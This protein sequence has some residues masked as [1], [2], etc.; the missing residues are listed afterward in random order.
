MAFTITLEPDGHQFSAKAYDTVLDSAVKAGHNIPYGCRNG[1][2]GSCKGK[3]ISGDVDYG[4][5]ADTALSDAE[6]EAG[7]ALL[8]CALP[9]SDLTIQSRETPADLAP[10]R[11]LPTRIESMT[12][13]ADDV[14]VMHLKLPKT[15]QLQFKAGQYLEFLLADGK[16]R[17]FSLAN[18]PH[19]P[20]L[21][22]HIR[23][24]PGGSFTEQVFNDLQEKA[25]MRI[26]APLGSFYLR[27]DSQKPIIMIAGGTGFAPIKGIIEYMI[28]ADIQRE[29]TLYWGAKSQKDLYMLALAQ[30]WAETQTNIR[31]IPVLSAANDTDAWQGRTGNVH[32][33]VLEDFENNA[34]TENPSAYEVYCCGAPV[35]VNAAQQSLI[36]KGL[37]EDSFYADI[38]S[39]AKPTS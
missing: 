4:D 5:Y 12:K 23:H 31:F 33:V 17:A 38:F 8:C 14:I 30:S 22:L 37:S 10:P 26:E 6:R 25:I 3:I 18:P 35:M 24:V 29:V 27:E 2:C 28:E 9:L 34:L 11:I 20:L 21:E 19:A 39:Y 15:E 7:N 36:E 1:T 32:Q 13:P 16:R